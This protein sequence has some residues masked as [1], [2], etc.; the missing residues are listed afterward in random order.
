[1]RCKSRNCSSSTGIPTNGAGDAA[2]RTFKLTLAY[3]GTAFAGWQFQP[4][5]RT[6]QAVLEEA[7]AAVT[8]LSGRALAAGRTDA[9]VHALGQI[10]SVRSDTRLTPE[11]LR[12]ALNARLPD[13]VAVIEAVEVPAS[14]HPI[15]HATGK[16]Y[17][18]LLCDARVRTVFRRYTSWHLHTRLDVDAMRRAAACLLGTHDFRSFQSQGS[19]RSSTVRTVRELTIAR[20]KGPDEDLVTLEIEADGFL[21]NMVRSIVGTLVEV[22]RGARP[23]GWVAAALEAC[24]RSAAGPKAPPQG[25]I[26]VRVNYTTA[27]TE[28]GG[29]P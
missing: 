18:Y 21:Y 6:V 25:L 10:V 3:D 1:M 8:G 28:Q 24:D 11:V 20:G 5:S 23:E 7:M 27:E 22:G 29:M 16:R 17:R 26:L 2:V 14:F 13:D 9:G 15:R 4:A 12:R 19:P